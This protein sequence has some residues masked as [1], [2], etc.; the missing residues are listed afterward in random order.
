MGQ[1]AIGTNIFLIKD[2]THPCT[3]AKKSPLS[4]CLELPQ[5]SNMNYVLD[6]MIQAF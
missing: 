1:L 2:I 4:R 3:Q 6:S 5:A